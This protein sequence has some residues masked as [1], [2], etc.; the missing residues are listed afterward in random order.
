MTGICKRLG[1][2][3][4]SIGLWGF[5]SG[6]ADPGDSGEHLTATGTLQ[7]PL[8]GTSASG[9]TYR[10]TGSL[11]IE[12]R[13]MLDLSADDDA[14]EAELA[15]GDYTMLLN[16]GWVL[17]HV[18]PDHTEEAVNATLTSDNP[19]SFTIANHATTVVAFTFRIDGGSVTLGKG[20]VSVVVDVDDGLV[21]D[22]E[23]GN[24]EVLRIGGRDGFWFTFNDGAGTQMPD[25]GEA[26]LPEPVMGGFAFHTHGSGFTTFAGAGASLKNNPAGGSLAY[27]ASGYGGVRF[28][29]RSD[30]PARFEV[31]TTATIPPPD[32]TC[33]GSCFD[34]HGFEL[35]AAPDWQSVQIEWSELAQRGFGDPAAFD[36]SQVHV[37]KWLFQPDD[38]DFTLD[39]VRLVSG[40]A[41][42]GAWSPV[43]GF[44]H[45][46][47]HAHLLPT[48][49]LLF[50]DVGHGVPA[51]FDP[52]SGS[53]TET[54]PPNI[55]VFCSGHSF[56]AD[57]RLFVAGGQDHDTNN[58]G[59][60]TAFA[61]DPSA[62]TWTQLANMN[63]GRWY[64]TNVT[65]GDG[66]VL[67][68]SGSITPG[69]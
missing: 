24:N 2:T 55:E 29:Y 18:L 40:A 6:C 49:Q 50:W 11:H 39:D 56:L 31:D 57:G 9:Q 20:T 38:F 33:T 37:L 66:K 60:D 42:L 65:L 13:T 44:P 30:R 10:L 16:D 68:T 23:D 4:V 3:I 51:L 58:D 17:S 52:A 25:P 15:V 21:D 69:V 41:R 14:V 46:P 7:T 43:I 27:D 8:I 12:G 5:A 59:L 62:N 67:V 26:A 36:P 63:D 34:S 22:F 19:V 61:Y 28:R 54:P 32:G 47:I 45:I 53:I 48:K 64:P 1:I 35:P